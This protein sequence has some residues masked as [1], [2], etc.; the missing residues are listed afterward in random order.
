M[1]ELKKKVQQKW[2][3]LERELKDWGLDLETFRTRASKA[4][5]ELKV[6]QEKQIATLRTK[7]DQARKKLDDARKAGGAATEEM[8]KG[9][10]AAWAELRKAFDAAVARFKQSEGSPPEAKGKPAE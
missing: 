2:A 7:M 8:E 3:Q 4:S 6:E 9:V 5:A 1:D 10:E